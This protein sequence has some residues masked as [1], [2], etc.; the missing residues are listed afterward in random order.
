MRLWL[1]TGWFCTALTAQA[2]TA[3]P[4]YLGSL[5]P[6]V[7]NSAVPAEWPAD[8]ARAMP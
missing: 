8:G 6:E 2:Q 1:L 4:D 7:S 5:Q 3:W